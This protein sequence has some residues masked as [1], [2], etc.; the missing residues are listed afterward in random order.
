MKIVVT[1]GLGHI[2]SRVIR[3][4]PAAFPG[5]EFVVVDN[6]VTQRFPSLFNLPDGVS[7]RFLDSDVMT[8]DLDPLIR[9]AGAV[10]HLAALTDAT[11]SF[12]NREAVERVNFG[13][14]ERVAKV[15]ATV[16][17][18]LIHASSTSV[19]GT[20]NDQVDENCDKS[21]LKPQSPYAETKLREEA[22]VAEL[23]R[24][25]G[26]RAVICRFGTIFGTSPG[27][28]F[29]TAVNKFCWQSV[30]GQPVTVWKTAYDQ[31]RPYLD[32][33]D[34]VEA[35]G[36]FIRRDL[37]DGRVYNVVTSNHTVR[38][39]VDAIRER[40]P[41]LQVTF[42]EERIMNQLSYDV[43]NTRLNE[44]GFG[45]RGSLRQGIADTIALLKNMNHG[46]AR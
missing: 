37:F 27:M 19:Y 23:A 36:F 12:N 34:A 14:T 4:L 8:M 44:A 5:A 20:Q 30:M 10:I 32:L 2:G 22:L 38:D 28:R 26:L 24:D 42:V 43:A 40:V 11:A 33:T 29:H 6:M 13:A 31:K 18:P 41:D 46:T 35:M 21:E 1:G 45:F 39:V 15:C 17:A 9:G 7:F 16:G 25:Q 3:Q